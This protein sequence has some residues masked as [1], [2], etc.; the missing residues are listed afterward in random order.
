MVYTQ[1]G[2]SYNCLAL[3]IIMDILH[4]LQA[5]S[6]TYHPFRYHILTVSVFLRQ[7]VDKMCSYSRNL[8]ACKNFVLRPHTEGS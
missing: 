8:S 5:S 7:N 6:M 1:T 2:V 4:K 3:N